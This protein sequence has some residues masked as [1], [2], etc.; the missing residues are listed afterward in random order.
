M[1]RMHFACYKGYLRWD[2]HPFWVGFEYCGQSTKKRV[3]YIAKCATFILNA[4]M[5]FDPK[6]PTIGFLSKIWEH[7][8]HVHVCILILESGG[9]QLWVIKKEQ[10]QQHSENSFNLEKFSFLSKVPKT[11]IFH[12]NHRILN[13]YTS[14]INK[15]KIPAFTI[16]PEKI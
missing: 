4:K 3:G 12:P 8:T 15:R 2:A 10:Q 14:T 9:E 13:S 11:Y 6:M 5:T 7:W 16:P 1:L